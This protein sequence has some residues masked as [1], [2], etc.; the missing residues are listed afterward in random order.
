M[1]RR[2]FQ[3]ATYTPT[4]T[5]DAS[6]LASG[7][8]QSIE[9]G[10]ATQMINVD[11]IQIGGQAPSA[12]SP[13]IFMFARNLTAATTPTALAAPNGDGPLNGSTAALA[14]PA[15]TYTAAATGPQRTNTATTARLNLSLNAYGGIV[16]WFANPGREW[17]IIGTSVSI[18]PSS[19]SCFTGGSVGLVGSHI[20]Y[21]PL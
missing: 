17:V 20:C 12:S 2:S 15:V 21:E 5:A 11:E 13:C 18:A 10:S 14:A 9:A 16:K 7:T 1:A 3:A 4:A 19:L 8:Y 6:A